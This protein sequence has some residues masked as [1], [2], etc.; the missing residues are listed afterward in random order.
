[1]TILK[2]GDK[3]IKVKYGYRATIESDIMSDLM[4]MSDLIGDMASVRKI[5]QFAPKML[6]VGLQKY[7]KDEYG[8]DF[9]NAD[10]VQKGIEKVY[11]LLDDYFDGENDIQAL[12]QILQNELMNNGFLFRAP[13][14]KKKA[15]IQ[16]LEAQEAP[17]TPESEEE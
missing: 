17:E 2:C 5:L 8:C 1:M 7:H 3:E 4:G 16:S 15:K 9:S 6:L 11:D 10:E 14:A 12:F 13:K